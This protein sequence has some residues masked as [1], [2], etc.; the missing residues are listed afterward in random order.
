[1][2]GIVAPLRLIEVLKLA[3]FFKQSA[4]GHLVLFP[5]E[6]FPEEVD[7]MREVGDGIG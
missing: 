4:D 5:G 2:L 6:V 7:F 1:V 3:Q